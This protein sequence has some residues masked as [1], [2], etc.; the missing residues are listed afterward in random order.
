MS[1]SRI[2]IVAAD[3]RVGKGYKSQ[4][5]GIFDKEI[6]IVLLNLK[7][8][9]EL[10]LGFD[11]ILA[12]SAAIYENVKKKA[13][14][15][16]KIVM[17]IRNINTLELYKVFNIESGS[18]ALVVSN[19][20]HAAEETVNLLTELGLNHIKYIPYCPDTKLEQSVLSSIDLAITAGAS[21]FIPSMIKRVVDLGL[22]VID[23]ST[24]LEIIISLGLPLQRINLFTFRY[25]KEFIAL[26]RKIS[27]LKSRLVTVL[28]ASSDGLIALD[29]EGSIIFNNNNLKIFLPG[30]RAINVGENIS[31]YIKDNNILN[32]IKDFDSRESD[33]FHINKKDIMVYK[34]Y[35]RSGE[36][37]TG[38]VISFSYVSEIQ[39]MEKEIRKKL[40][41]KG[42]MAKYDFSDIIGFSKSIKT[43]TDMTKKVART[44]LSALLLG[45]NGT[46]KELFAQAIHR[47]SSRREGPFVAVNFAALSENL[48]ESELFGYEEGA[49]TGAK[50]GG[51]LGLFELA[52]IGTIF[53]D[54]I[55]DAPLSVQARLLRVIQE[56]EVLRV[57]G[58]SPIPVDVRVIAA[59]N[60]DLKELIKINMF[61]KDLYYRLNTI[62]IKIP[63]LRERKED[64]PYII[65]YYMNN[66]NAKKIFT[67]DAIKMLSEYNWPGNVRELENL[68]HY[69]VEIV[70][71]DVI[72]ICDLP[73]DIRMDS[74]DIKD[75]EEG[76]SENIVDTLGRYGNVKIYKLILSELKLAEDIYKKASRSYLVDRLLKKGVP[77]T[78]NILRRI[79]GELEEL[80]CISIGSTKQGT[81]VTQKGKETLEKLKNTLKEE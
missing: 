33:V 15:N 47:N 80:E 18:T 25:M 64:I 59:T 62:T 48:I 74:E 53:L 6:E 2:A 8:D 73:M 3:E 78:D 79:L 21:H 71:G 36:K 45:E 31:K 34:N 30:S 42:Y 72:D 58:M 49:F 26:N 46:G 14:L 56:K 39:D 51:K 65:D 22:K 24:V 43:A 13:P 52:H 23:I 60:K 37:I 67:D 27:D 76:F 40:N 19:Y 7:D 10:F 35:L 61:R 57:G 20:L 5:E 32:F 16:A 66:L 55:G 12:A 63:P 50:K 38:T 68:I 81:C 29:L 44:D 77:M 54:E 1:N 75:K 28:D 70:D 11:L 41:N 9:P 17:V 69:G 4:L